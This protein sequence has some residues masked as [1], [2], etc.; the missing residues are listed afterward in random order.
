M[1]INESFIR[2]KLNHKANALEQMKNAI[3]RGTHRY[4]LVPVKN[5]LNT[6]WGVKAPYVD[7]NKKKK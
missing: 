3:G 1:A 4:I 6:H 2:M 5:N 7:P